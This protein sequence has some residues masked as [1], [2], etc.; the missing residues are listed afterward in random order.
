V[1]RLGR[2]GDQIAVRLEGVKA[3]SVG[4]DL[5]QLYSNDVDDAA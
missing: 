2:S 1:A 5:Q 3:P 4:E